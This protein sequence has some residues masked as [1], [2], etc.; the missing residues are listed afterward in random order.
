MNERQT[1][2]ELLRALGELSDL[3]PNWRL[4]QTLANLAMFAG[5]TDEGGVWELEDSEALAAIRHLLEKQ[6]ASV[7][8][9]S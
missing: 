3:H 2:T 5:R 4:G 1:R 8:A 7:S 6:N 9:Q